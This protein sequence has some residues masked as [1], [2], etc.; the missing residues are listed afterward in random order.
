MMF[1]GVQALLFGAALCASSKFAFEEIWEG[2]TDI[3][4]C[5]EV[6]PFISAVCD[7][8]LDAHAFSKFMV[9]DLGC[10]LPGAMQVLQLVSNRAVTEHG[11]NSTWAV[12][13]Q[14]MHSSYKRYAEE[15][16]QGWNLGAVVPSKSCTN[17]V[18]FLRATAENQPL[19]QSAVAFA[20]CK[21]LWNW[22]GEQL[23]PCLQ[24]TS[25]YKSFIEG[26]VSSSAKSKMAK[27]DDFLRAALE[28]DRN[29]TM[30]T[31]RASMEL[32]YMFF[33]SFVAGFQAPQT[34]ACAPQSKVDVEL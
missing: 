14:K 5:V 18:D 9:Q 20:P 1:K 34:F 7:G 29:I 13:F 30:T 8:T 6:S 10:Y 4:Q 28:N 31:F 11:A 33:N 23:K 25:A 24:K 2:A 22:L 3:A 32:E 21:L 17:Y 12:Y 26:M 27:I 15:G 19:V 16:M